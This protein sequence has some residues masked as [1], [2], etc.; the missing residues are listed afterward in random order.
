MEIVLA[1]SNY[2]KLREIREAFSIINKSIELLLYSDLIDKFDIIEDGNSFVENAII[3]AK[4][5]KERL[6]N[7]IILSDDSGISVEKLDNRPN[8]YSAR[9]A[10]DSATDRDNRKK[11]ISEMI[12]NGIEKSRAFYTASMALCIGDTLYT[13]HGWLYG[14]VIIEQRGSNGFGY[15]SMFIPDGYNMTLGELD[16]HTKM[17][18]SHRYMALRLINYFL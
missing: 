13:S 8:I 7:H 5:I 4:T 6:P 11:L 17:V 18:I 15:D 2:G 3:K 12:S 9:Y 16:N 10:G 1:T 14:D